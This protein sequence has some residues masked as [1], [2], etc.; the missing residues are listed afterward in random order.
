MPH[1]QPAVIFM[2]CLLWF[3]TANS[4]SLSLP[5]YLVTSLLKWLCTTG[6]ANLVTVLNCF[7]T[8]PPSLIPVYIC[9]NISC[10]SILRVIFLRKWPPKYYIDEHWSPPASKFI[11]RHIGTRSSIVQWFGAL[12]LSGKFV[13][14]LF[15]T[16]LFRCLPWRCFI[17]LSYC[18]LKHLLFIV[19]GRRDD[20][21]RK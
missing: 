1:W 18:L 7:S 14:Q 5:V 15:A 10:S 2:Y 19:M 4:L 11:C 12:V 6:G 13:V 3:V 21:P 20:G 9:K 8:L 17:L 16:H